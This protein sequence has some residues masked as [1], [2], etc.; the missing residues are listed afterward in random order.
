M[1][2]RSILTRQAL[3]SSITTQNILAL[4]PR[5]VRAVYELLT[6]DFNPLELCAKLAPLMADVANVASPMSAASPVKDLNMGLYVNSLKQVTALPA[7]SCKCSI[8]QLPVFPTCSQ[9]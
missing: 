4:V 8:V 5:E 9:L 1:D 2:Y 7:A 6:S 3:L